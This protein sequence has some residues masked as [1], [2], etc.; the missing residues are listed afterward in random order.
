MKLFG[1]GRY[2]PKFK[3]ENFLSLLE[4]LED[5]TASIYT[6]NMEALWSSETLLPYRITT[7][8]HNSEYRDLNL[9]RRD[10]SRE[11]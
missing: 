3:Q 8:R 5:H 7:R 6:P 11:M 4:W 10:K 1:F 2:S 9:Y